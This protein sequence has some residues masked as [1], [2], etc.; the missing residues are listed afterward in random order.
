M[1]RYQYEMND[2]AITE[3]KVE[4]EYEFRITVKT[5]EQHKA[6]QDIRAFF[7][8]NRLHTDV[9]FYT[10]LDHSYQ[11]IVREDYYVE[12]LLALFKHR[13]LTQLE[14]A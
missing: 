3:N 13:L 4:K 6:M 10:H 1:V 2:L 14:W 9:M 8:H 5:E 7:D 11:V 12:F